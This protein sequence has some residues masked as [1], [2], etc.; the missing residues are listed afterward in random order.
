MSNNIFVFIPIENETSARFVTV[1]ETKDENRL[2]RL[3]CR[4]QAPNDEIVLYEI[5]S[6]LFYTKSP[7]PAPNQK[8]NLKQNICPHLQQ[9]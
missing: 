2:P 4:V 6:G 3:W 7:D 8:L 9:A 5:P 1:V